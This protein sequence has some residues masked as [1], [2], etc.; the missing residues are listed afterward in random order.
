MIHPKGTIKRIREL[1]INSGLA[2][3]EV[4]EEMIDH[5][6]CEIESKM[7][8]N[9]SPQLATH[10]VYQKIEKT[11]FS[12]LQKRKKSYLSLFLL[13]VFIVSLSFYLFQN[14]FTTKKTEIA[15]QIEDVA[16]D[17][18]PLSRSIIKVTS[19]FGM[20]M[21]PIFKSTKLH[22]GIDIK[23]RVGEPVVATGE[24]VVKE[25]GF[26]EA[27]GN[28]IVLEHNT[29]FSS[30][31]C[32]LSSINVK[33]NELVIKGSV[34]GKVGNTGMSLAPHLHYELM[35]SEAHVDPLE[36]IRP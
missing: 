8:Q 27:A 35:D 23:A 19:K 33:K 6:L 21:H 2:N 11:D 10:Y 4:L 30:R 18:W 26:S 13:S 15:V 22:K 24:A 34:I 1:L 17:G 5:Y 7:D 32:H 28:Y 25:T 36:Y 16:P 9:V 14:H 31:Y 3:G 29:R 12:T 20:R